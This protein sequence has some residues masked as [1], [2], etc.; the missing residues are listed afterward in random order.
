MKNLIKENKTAIIIGLVVIVAIGSYYFIHSEGSKEGTQVSNEWVEEE[1]INSDKSETN[2]EQSNVQ[3]EEKVIVDL[4]GAIKYPGVYE[5][6]SG[7]RVIDVIES[8]GGLHENADKNNINFAMKL[9]DEMVLYI[10]TIGE[11]NV[12]VTG[13]GM[14]QADDGKINLN[15]ASEVELQTLTGVGPSKANAIIEYR[16]E[17][18]S[19]KEIEELMEISGIGEKTFE[20]FKDQ[21]T[22]R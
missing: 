18:G 21:I 11:E 10:P 17:N 1:P 3:Q 8:A 9:V 12:A 2:E 16:D 5:V 13:E 19:F 4:K 7:D 6:Q 22:V 14:V 15:K 20:K